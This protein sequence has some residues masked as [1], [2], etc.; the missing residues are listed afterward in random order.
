VLAGSMLV[1]DEPCCCSA[2]MSVCADMTVC[3]DA[4]AATPRT[5]NV[6][7]RFSIGLYMTCGDEVGLT[8]VYASFGWRRWKPVFC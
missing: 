2:S 8:M 3:A 5:M 6:I 7:A 4:D 1:P